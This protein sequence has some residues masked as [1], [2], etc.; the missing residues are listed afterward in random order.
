MTGI[1]WTAAAALLLLAILWG[2]GCATL[3]E[4]TKIGT[5]SRNHRGS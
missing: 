5:P 3:E 4:A 2:A 1:R